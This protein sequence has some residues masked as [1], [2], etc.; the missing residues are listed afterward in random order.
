MLIFKSNKYRCPFCNKFL[1]HFSY[2]NINYYNLY[3]YTC[4]FLTSK[5]KNTNDDKFWSAK[6]NIN[7]ESCFIESCKKYNS[8]S[9]F[10]NEKIFKIKIYSSTPNSM[11]ELNNLKDKLLKL[12]IYE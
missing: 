2:D 3:C 4:E 11:E 5:F 9:F 8:T 12:K 7:N 10:I 6:L 1:T